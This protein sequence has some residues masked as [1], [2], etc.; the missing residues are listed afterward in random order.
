MPFKAVPAPSV[1]SQGGAG[2][3]DSGLKV[4]LDVPATAI[5]DAVLEFTVRLTN[6][7]DAAFDL[8]PCPAYM[9]N[10]GESATLTE[11]NYLLNCGDAPSAIPAGGSVDLAMELSLPPGASGPMSVTWRLGQV[12]SPRHPAATA[13]IHVRRKRA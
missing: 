9:M 2:K 7:S 5:E 13:E 12:L 6:E 4:H 8:D 1:S 10:V 11:R 3:Y